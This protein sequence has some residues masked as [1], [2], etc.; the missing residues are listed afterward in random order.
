[1]YIWQLYGD[2]K[3]I[4]RVYSCLSSSLYGA[5]TYYLNDEKV[6]E[7][8]SEI[9][10]NFNEAESR[11]ASEAGIAAFRD[12][13]EKYGLSGKFEMG[14]YGGVMML[15]YDETD[16]TETLLTYIQH[17]AFSETNSVGAQGI[18]LRIVYDY[19]DLR[20]KLSVV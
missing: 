17:G 2:E 1:M 11:A 8:Y 5:S 4:S 16:K 6:A 7:Y 14:E 9:G 13:A 20:A 19:T 3:K 15:G 12:A 18:D 10:M